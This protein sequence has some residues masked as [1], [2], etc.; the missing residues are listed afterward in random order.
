MAEPTSTECR[1]L[2]ETRLGQQA[3]RRWGQ[4]DPA[5]RRPNTGR[6]I[7]GDERAKDGLLAIDH[8]LRGG[9]RRR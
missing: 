5:L 9:V 8:R 4:A 7:A 6:L 1:R 3:W 2:E